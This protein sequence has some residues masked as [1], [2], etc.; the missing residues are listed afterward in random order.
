MISIIQYNIAFWSDYFKISPAT[1]R[2][3][4]NYLAY[5]VVDLHTKEVKD[6]LYFVDVD[7]ERKKNMIANLDRETYLNF[8]EKDYEQRM[9]EEYGDE[10]G[11]FGKIST[12]Q[13]LGR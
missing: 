1:I 4:V 3:I 9:I 6:V 5:P 8:L 2:N 12:S 13:E 11:Y 7:L 10:A